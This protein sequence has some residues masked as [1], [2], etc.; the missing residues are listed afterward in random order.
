MYLGWIFAGIS[1]AVCLVIALLLSVAIFRKRHFPE[2]GKSD[3][4]R[5]GIENDGA[6]MKWIFVGT[7]I[8]ICILFAM[9]VYALVTLN[10]AANLPSPPV[11]SL[12]VTGYDWWWKVDYDIDDP[13][14]RIVTANEIHI[15]VGVPILL[16]LNSAD[17]IHA[18]WVPLLAGKTQMIPGLTNQQW[19]QADAPG[20]YRGQCTQYCGVQHAHMALE[21]V[22]QSMADF[23]AW[24][25]AQRTQ[26]A[27]SNIP[28]VV[29]GE[30][31]FIDRCGACHTIRGTEAMG[32]HAPD[33][34]HLISRRLIAAGLMTN[35]P[36]HRLDWIMHAQQLKPGSRMP[37]IALAPTEA[38]D[39]AAFLSTLN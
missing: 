25:A 28:G 36:E 14:R 27:A 11:L 10:R 37:D 15:P 6:G 18:F 5:Y 7:G 32:A 12:T 35:T 30:K 23:R 4:I 16:K 21:V 24:E 19:L 13:S 33:L 22:A 17:V 38:A 3:N 34:T 31:L 8:S 2:D 1:I 20:I 26:I 39:L 9:A 29:A